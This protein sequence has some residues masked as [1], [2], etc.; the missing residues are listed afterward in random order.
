MRDA[1]ARYKF[2]HVIKL[3]DVL[4]TPGWTDPN[5]IDIINMVIKALRSLPMEGARV[6]DIGCRDGIF[7]FEAEKLGA[8]EVLG[9]D[10][11]LSRAAVEF[12]IP[13]F[14]SRVKMESLNMYDLNPEKHGK[15][16]VICFSG[17]LYHLRY[18][19]WG[20][21]CIREVLKPGG[22]LVIH[23]AMYVDD[24]KLAMLFCPIGDECPGD[25]P[26][27]CTNFNLKGLVD[28]LHSLG[29]V[30]RDAEYL[31]EHGLVAKPDPDA[32]R[33]HARSTMRSLLSKLGLLPDRAKRIPITKH[34]FD[35]QFYFDSQPDLKEA[36]ESNRWRDSGFAHYK[37][38]GRKERRL[39]RLRDGTM[40]T[41][42]QPVDYPEPS[43]NHAVFV[44]RYTPEIINPLIN[45][46]WETTHDVH[47]MAA[48]ESFGAP[49]KY[50]K[51][52]PVKVSMYQRDVP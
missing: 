37:T 32:D 34:T 26:T 31:W 5:T 36:V 12:L 17:V 51:A 45:R 33:H 23:T 50:P 40:I 20:L 11:D 7:S 2:Y 28:T 22:H 14:K 27:H 6:L 16:D 49:G 19:V 46:Y 30:V 4:S 1:L 48:G 24:N 3:T 38:H 41:P 21:R 15:F 8:K 52:A 44:C 10:N 13:Y 18:P 9:I 43:I 29:I 47:N 35:E 39:A 25:D 42:E